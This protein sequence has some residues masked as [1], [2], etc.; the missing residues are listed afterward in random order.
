MWIVFVVT[1]VV[2]GVH[3]F[4]SLG[5]VV[6]FRVWRKVRSIFVVFALLDASSVFGYR[7]FLS[8]SHLE[9]ENNNKNK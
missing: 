8:G 7:V 5:C 1:V 9:L 4:A 2:S 6:V 3:C